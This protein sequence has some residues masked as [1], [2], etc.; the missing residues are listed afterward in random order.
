MVG[1]IFN[2]RDQP[3]VAEAGHQGLKAPASAAFSTIRATVSIFV[4]LAIR[5]PARKG[6]TKNGPAPLHFASTSRLLDRSAR[7]VT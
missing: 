5:R 2:T 4:H 1:E 3:R 6:L 7:K